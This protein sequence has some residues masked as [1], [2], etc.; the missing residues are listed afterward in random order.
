M[1]KKCEALAYASWKTRLRGAVHHLAVAA[2]LWESCVE[3]ASLCEDGDPRKEHM[4]ALQ[5]DDSNFA[6]SMKHQLLR[7][8]DEL[9]EAEL[10]G[11][12]AMRAKEGADARGV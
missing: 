1:D 9:Q 11:E 6:G 12:E 7:L 2:T 8:C 4:K 10:R 5:G 3:I